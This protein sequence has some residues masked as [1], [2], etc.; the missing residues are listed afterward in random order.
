MPSPLPAGVFRTLM[1]AF[2]S[3]LVLLRVVGCAFG[4]PFHAA[5]YGAPC[6]CYTWRI[7]PPRLWHSLLSLHMA[8]SPTQIMVLPIIVTH[9]K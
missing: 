3:P 2:V 4:L 6:C 9:G 5:G 8:N 1:G 7:V